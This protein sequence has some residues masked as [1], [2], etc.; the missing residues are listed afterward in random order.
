MKILLLCPIGIG[1]YL[2]TYPTFS[3]IKKALPNCEL[4]LLALR[5]GL[6]AFTQS[7]PLFNRVLI[8]E[9]SEFRSV[10][11]KFRFIREIRSLGCDTAI[12]FF[13]S[14][15]LE[16]NMLLFLSGAQRRI[17]FRYQLKQFASASFLANYH[18]EAKD[19]LHDV[20]QNLRVLE[21]LGAKAPDHLVF[22]KLFDAADMAE[23]S[24]WLEQR[25]LNGKMLIG[26]HPGSSA[27]HGMVAKRWP[28]MHFAE[29]GK[30]LV[31]EYNAVILVFGGPEEN[32]IKRTVAYLCGKETYS[33]EDISL[34]QSA[35][36]ISQCRFF[37]S[38]DSGLM[39]VA[40]LSGVPTAGIFGPTDDTRTAPWGSGHL[41]LRNADCSP[42]WTISNVGVRK[43]CGYKAY[44]CI[45]E[46]S[47]DE[48]FERIRQWRRE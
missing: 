4:N 16:Y 44:R 36:L 19:G 26:M 6:S 15:R 33:V 9:P 45:K 28:E 12:S 14:N 17:A 2:L 23:A 24:K 8:A 18:I 38:N 46:L 11:R 30:R 35:A 21:A 42:C 7:D 31:Q 47:V 34:R 48:V 41:V 37:V 1:N 39:H 13:P 27:E 20:S 32:P 10:S 3:A 5:K 29:L 40:A 25:G 43:N 22:P